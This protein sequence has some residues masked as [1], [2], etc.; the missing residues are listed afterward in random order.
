MDQLQLVSTVKEALAKTRITDIHTHIYPGS[1]GDFSLW[2]ID[3]LLTYHYLIAETMR[4]IDLPYEQFWALEK[5]AQ[6]DLVW[7]TLFVGNTPYSE[8]CRGV[9]TVLKALGL[10]TTKR[11]LKEYR[12]YF[13]AQDPAAY[14]DRVFE[15]SGVDTVVMTNDPFSEQE[16]WQEKG[17]HDERFKAVLRIDTLLVD[18]PGAVP[19]LRGLGYEVSQTID[20]KTCEQVRRFLTDWIGRM[21]PLYIAASLP[22]DFTLPNDNPG[23]VM[24][25]QCV[26]PVC[27]EYGLPFAAMI[28]VVRRINQAL[29]DAGDAVGKVDIGTVGYL[30]AHY[31]EN[32]FLVTLLSRENQHEL[33]VFARKFRNLQVFGCW[34]FLNNPSLIEEITRMRMELLGTS[35]IPQH[36]DA[37]VLDQLIYKWTHSKEVIGKVLIDKY[38]DLMDTG[39]IVTPDEIQRDVDKLFSENFWDFLS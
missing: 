38:S 14:I 32:K 26:L 3:E 5:S 7:Q 39:W 6:A 9:L 31:P 13:N 16:Y 22:Y 15:L 18:W 8:A 21:S 2:G 28:G 24:L 25:D 37:R 34:W 35:F 23:A 33:A 4:W 36:S 10:D 1:F 29:G 30:C 19:K 27:R 20:S 11:D 12:E 17:I